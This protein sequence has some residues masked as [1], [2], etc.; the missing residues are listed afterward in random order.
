MHVSMLAFYFF[1]ISK[2]RS[3]KFSGNMI[4]ST[5]FSF[6][7]EVALPNIYFR[8]SVVPEKIAEP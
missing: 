6:L 3:L 7:L 8:E 2:N 4:Q 1:V 5:V